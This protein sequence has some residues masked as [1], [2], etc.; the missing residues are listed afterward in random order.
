MFILKNSTKKF[1]SIF[2]IE[3]FFPIRI[4]QVEVYFKKNNK[5]PLVC[6]YKISK[7]ALRQTNHFFKISQ[8]EDKNSYF[9]HL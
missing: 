7:N 4:S 3:I 9:H 1:Y 5:I 2:L 6:N 8:I